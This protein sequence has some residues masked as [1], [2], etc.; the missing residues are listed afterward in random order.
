M[1][2]T[3]RNPFTLSLTKHPDTNRAVVGAYLAQDMREKLA[4]AALVKGTS[5]SRIIEIALSNAL[6]NKPI[7]SDIRI[8]AGRIQAEWD[9]YR[10]ANQGK[11]G[12]NQQEEMIKYRKIVKCGLMKSGIS[13]T[14]TDKIMEKF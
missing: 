2:N 6:P 4:M 1:R 11:D 12:W 13:K 3:P 9:L 5:K 8:L 10:M 14:T 7:D